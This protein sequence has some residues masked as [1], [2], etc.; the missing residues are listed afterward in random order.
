[1]ST[2]NPSAPVPPSAPQYPPLPKVAGA[3]EHAQE[4]ATDADSVFANTRVQLNDGTYVEI[5]PHPNFN[6]LGDDEQT[7]YEQLLFEVK[8]YDREPSIYVPESRL[9]DADGNETGVV[10]PART[11]EGAVIIPHQQT[12]ENGKTELI[13]P[14]YNQRMVRAALGPEKYAKLRAGGKS[15][16]DVIKAWSEQTIRITERQ[17]FRPETNGSARPVA[18]LPR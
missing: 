7:A 9:K 1:M 18:Q 11:L 13:T 5:P 2:P 16:G 15:A 17:N 4:Q 14:P 6:M 3:A 8:S 12:D 10:F